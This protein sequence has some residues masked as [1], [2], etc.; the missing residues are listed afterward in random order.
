MFLKKIVI[1]MCPSHSL[2]KYHIFFTE[3]LELSFDGTL[4][5]FSKI[6]HR[7]TVLTLFNLYKEKNVVK[8]LSVQ[9]QTP[10]THIQTFIS[11]FILA[12]ARRIR[13]LG[14]ET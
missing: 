7:I 2:H 3:T 12:R 11:L 9:A 4:S 13:H 5:E 14:N 6:F 8:I 1:A 10:F